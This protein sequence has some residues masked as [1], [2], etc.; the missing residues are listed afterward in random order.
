MRAV[1]TAVAIVSCVSGPAF[2]QCPEAD[3][4]KLEQF[5]R[6]WGDA[7]DRGD[8]AQLQGIYA[9]DFAGLSVSTGF[10]G[11]TQTIDTA[12]RDSERARTSARPAPKVVHDYYM[13][14]CT[15]AT[16]TITHRNVI[17]TMVDGKEK[18]AYSRSVHFLEKRAGRW[19]VVS[20]AGNPL[21]DAA[22]LLYMEREW[23]DA[24]LTRD[25][26]WHERNYSD[27]FSGISSR[28]G[29]LSTK[30]E[31]IA[32]SKKATLTSANLSEL[33]VRVEGNTAVVTGINHV[34]GTDDKGAAFDRT[35]RFTDT[36]VKRDGRWLVWATQGTAIS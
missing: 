7:G 2:A 33:D 18:T 5:D 34:T 35:V 9:D 23:N 22:V 3:Q 24:D 14:G 8:R 16:A 29:A 32:S 36:F 12:V 31:D 26:A 17:T 15:P 10:T 30:S 28:T 25:Y 27:D 21:G 13:I 4:K 6:A 19:Q 11:K 1:L 20:T